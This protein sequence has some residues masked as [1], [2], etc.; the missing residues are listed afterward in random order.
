MKANHRLLCFILLLG[1]LITGCSAN[2]SIEP[3]VVLADTEVENATGNK[4]S[5]ES[6]LEEETDSEVLT[7]SELVEAS[8]EF[9]VLSGDYFDQTP[10]GDIAE[11]FAPGI[12]SR[13]DRLENQ[14]AFSPDG[15]SVYFQMYTPDYV[16]T[17]FYTERLDGVWT[18]PVEASFAINKNIQLSSISADGNRLYL[19][20]NDRNNSELFKI[21]LTSEG[22]GELELLPNP[23]NSDASEGSYQEMEDGTAYLS[24]SRAGSA[25]KDLWRII[26]LTD[27]TMK[28]ENLGQVVNSDSW[29]FSPCIAPDGSYLIFGSDRNGRKGLAHLYI[30]FDDGNGGWTEPVNLNS[31]G[32]QVNDDF[33]NQ[34][35]AALS[36]DGAY[37]FFM[38][39]YDMATMDVYW[40]ST[41]FIDDIKETVFNA[42]T[43]K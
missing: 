18:E 24:S 43:A 42:D 35:C 21:E 4:V 7:Q 13:T 10:P 16:S 2:T 33:A 5:E 3:E 19:S 30:S 9:P 26:S 37:L 36:P 32:A 39:H 27:G 29:E 25:G 17:V 12:I 40:I 15:N 34:S 41:S 14:I 11:I 23:I 20:T 6:A 22:W 28:A 1:L 8:T 31:S 38:R